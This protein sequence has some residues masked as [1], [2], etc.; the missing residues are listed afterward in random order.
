MKDELGRETL[1]PEDLY[2]I[3]E[4]VA[5]RYG[6]EWAF[7]CFDIFRGGTIPFP[8][9]IYSLQ[10][11]YDKM[12]ELKESGKYSTREIARF[13]GCSE[14]WVRSVIR[15]VNLEKSGSIT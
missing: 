14:R 7:Q 8:N 2:G 1:K 6:V 12:W 9:R 5:S 15:K 11:K 13:F 3:Y 4:T 10:F